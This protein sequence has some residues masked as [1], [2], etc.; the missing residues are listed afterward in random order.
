MIAALA[1]AQVDDAAGRIE[2]PRVGV[3]LIDRRRQSAVFAGEA[4]HGGAR[5][6]IS[7]ALGLAQLVYSA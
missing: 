1:G 4:H 5:L 2:Q 7:D 3:P 6:C